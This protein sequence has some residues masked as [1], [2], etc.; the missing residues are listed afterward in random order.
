M[1]I[2]WV[3]KALFAPRLRLE[4]DFRAPVPNAYELP[5]DRGLAPLRSARGATASAGQPSDSRFCQTVSD[6]LFL[7]QPFLGYRSINNVP[8]LSSAIAVTCNGRLLLTV[9]ALSY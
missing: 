7:C 2:S 5:R 8:K 1:V 4:I 9:R 3:V 6:E